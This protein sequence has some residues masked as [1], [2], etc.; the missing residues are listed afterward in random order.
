MN[1]PY[2]NFQIYTM[3]HS[4]KKKIMKIEQ[5]TRLYMYF[6]SKAKKNYQYGH[7]CGN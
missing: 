5:N 6:P 7:F 1:K 3:N 2:A 4:F